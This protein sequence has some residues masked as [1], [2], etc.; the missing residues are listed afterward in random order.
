MNRHNIK[1]CLLDL[2][3][4]FI[5]RA[6]FTAYIC[7]TGQFCP[8]VRIARSGALS[9]K[10]DLYIKLITI[11]PNDPERAESAKHITKASVIWFVLGV[12]EGLFCRRDNCILV[13]SVVYHCQALKSSF[14][15][16]EQCAAH[17]HHTQF[18]T[19]CSTHTPHTSAITLTTLRILSS[20]LVLIV[21]F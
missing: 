18:G 19:M 17:I 6:T 5:Q 3:H 11:N 10:I 8:A 9:A 13:V 2:I 14:H 7:V 16:L 15:N 1:Y 21:C 4:R 20:Q 12:S